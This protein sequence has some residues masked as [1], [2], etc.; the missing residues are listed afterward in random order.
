MIILSTPCYTGSFLGLG[1]DVRQNFDALLTTECNKA[2][3]TN[4]KVM[5][6]DDVGSKQDGR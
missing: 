3:K 5:E 2:G 6:V 1:L 4:S